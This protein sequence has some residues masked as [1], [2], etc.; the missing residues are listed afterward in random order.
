MAT[1]GKCGAT[2]VDGAHVRGC[3]LKAY[4]AAGVAADGLAASKAPR[5]VE[6]RR[7]ASK[8]KPKPKP[9]Q[10][11]KGTSQPSGA[12]SGTIRKAP[13]SEQVPNLPKQKCKACGRL[14]NPMSG[15]CGC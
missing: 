10:V 11:S 1:C 6:N 7:A 2:N 15:A 14:V 9:R 5:V 12:G 8:K 4:R 3:Y 13:G